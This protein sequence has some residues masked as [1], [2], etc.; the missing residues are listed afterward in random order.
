MTNITAIADEIQ[1]STG[2][3]YIGHTTEVSL[4][5]ICRPIKT[6]RGDNHGKKTFHRIWRAQ[7]GKTEL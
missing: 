1:Q 7:I 4:H 2:N 5:L 6:T 3:T